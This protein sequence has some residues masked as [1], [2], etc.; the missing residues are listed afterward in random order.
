MKL[1]KT[2]EFV[3]VSGWIMMMACCVAV[4]VTY[5]YLSISA[6]DLSDYAHTVIGFMFG[7]LPLM[8]KDLLLQKAAQLA[9]PP[10]P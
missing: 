1:E 7:S 2:T 6:K 4:V 10:K 3:I 9:A 5:A 8:L